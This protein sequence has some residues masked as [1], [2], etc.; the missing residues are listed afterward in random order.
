MYTW[1]PGTHYPLYRSEWPPTHRDIHREPISTSQALGLKASVVFKAVEYV[2]IIEMTFL[3]LVSLV[4]LFIS[5]LSF[6]SEI[7]H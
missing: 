4:C 2:I 7:Q 3:W 6:M 5:C 1:W